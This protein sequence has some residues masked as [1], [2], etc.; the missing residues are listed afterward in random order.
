MEP[1]HSSAL[2]STRCR[3]SDVGRCRATTCHPIE[4]SCSTMCRPRNPVPPVTKAVRCTTQSYMGR[5]RKRSRGSRYLIG[6]IRVQARPWRLP[7]AF[8]GACADR[9]AWST[10][11][12]VRRPW[13][14]TMAHRARSY[15]PCECGGAGHGVRQRRRELGRSRLLRLPRQRVRLPLRR[16]RQRRRL[17]SAPRIQRAKAGAPETGDTD[18]GSAEAGAEAAADDASASGSAIQAADGATAAA[19]RRP[20]QS[21]RRD[22]RRRRGGRPRNVRRGGVSRRDPGRRR[23][24]ADDWRLPIFPADNPWNTRVDDPQAY[25]VH[26]NSATYIASMS[27]GPTFTRTGATGRAA[28]TASPGRR[29]RPAS[30]WCP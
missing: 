26:P 8:H 1:T 10:H 28:S 20:R 14:Q 21:R 11:R 18:A 6:E 5:P 29:C 23:Q 30:R 7:A 2:H 9:L 24:R 25:P 19:I 3:T 22:V 15:V 16:R 12:R 13:R 17:R 4:V 27:P